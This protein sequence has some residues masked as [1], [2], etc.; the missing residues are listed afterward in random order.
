MGLVDESRVGNGNGTPRVAVWKRH[1]AST[2]DGGVGGGVSRRVVQRGRTPPPARR[3]TAVHTPVNASNAAKARLQGAPSSTT[4][5]QRAPRTRSLPRQAQSQAHQTDRSTMHPIVLKP[6]LSRPSRG[7]VLRGAEPQKIPGAVRCIVA[8][9]TTVWCAEADGDLSIREKDGSVFGVVERAEGAPRV[10]CMVF[11]PGGHSSARVV[12][13]HADG[14]A[15]SIDAARGERRTPDT[16]IHEG[17]L[18]AMVTTGDG[19]ILSSGADAVLY[20]LD[21][22]TVDI[23]QH[24]GTA[25]SAVTCVAAGAGRLFSGGTSGVVQMWWPRGGGGSDATHDS[26]CSTTL[27]GTISDVVVSGAHLWVAAQGA[28]IT[29]LDTTTLDI[30]TSIGAV[31]EGVSRITICGSGLWAFHDTGTITVWNM[32]TLSQ[33]RTLHSGCSGTAVCIAR[34]PCVA[35]DAEV[36]TANGTDGAVRT[37]RDDDYTVPLWCVQGLEEARSATSE[38][39]QALTTEQE[40]GE[41]LRGRVIALEEEMVVVKRSA[42][43]ERDG[44]SAEVERRKR[45]EVELSDLKAMLVGACRALS[46]ESSNGDVRAMLGELS[47]SAR[48]A[49]IHRNDVERL[50]ESLA[51]LQADNAE[52]NARLASHI[53]LLNTERSQTATTVQNL[54]KATQECEELQ[55]TVSSKEAIIRGLDAKLREMEDQ[56]QRQ[57]DSTEVP[58]LEAKLHAAEEEMRA[59]ETVI[60]ELRTSEI[61]LQEQVEHYRELVRSVAHREDA[62]TQREAAD[63][64]RIAELMQEV[65]TLKELTSRQERTPSPAPTPPPQDGPTPE[66]I[67]VLQSRIVDLEE[68]L[69]SADDSAAVE[70]ELLA[71]REHALGIKEN[72][73]EVKRRELGVREA[74]FV[75]RERMFEKGAEAAKATLLQGEKQMAQKVESLLARE[76]ELETR[77]EAL[78]EGDC[79]VIRMTAELE[80]LARVLDD[81]EH[82]LT[83]REQ[84]KAVEEIATADH[85]AALQAAEQALQEGEEARAVL[86]AEG[87]ELRSDIGIMMSELERVKD[88]LIQVCPEQALR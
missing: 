30:V 58:T 78:K 26:V 1:S 72:A 88:D 33:T 25:T 18:T 53:D 63:Q 3:G 77:A 34:V 10:T 40:A 69:A 62:M 5:R 39:L 85:S 49:E 59:K 76:A 61:D 27:G 24:I 11:V 80:N 79:S 13:G 65:E 28:A 2:P 20:L 12:I 55:H 86:V 36:W 46:T 51:T 71:R 64:D 60:E 56:I 52:A 38:A 84:K 82:H 9:D 42:D 48:T 8:A 73:A 81:R 83:K 15:A 32:Q 37:W 70:A 57:I 54:F 75:E 43:T 4:P 19:L 31:R 87:E 47:A 14:T 41:V 29:L 16:P 21:P 35:E 17:A 74:A 66:D 45:V 22:H 23:I 6:R 68:R 44:G 50:T 7:E 67:L